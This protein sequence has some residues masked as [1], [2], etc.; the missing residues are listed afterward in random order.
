MVSE[1]QSRRRTRSPKA[2]GI[3]LQD[4]LR[5]VDKVYGAYGHG[6]FSRAE[7]ASAM[8]M[9]AESG[10]FLN[11]VGAVRDYG[12]V[13]GRGDDMRVTD[14][15]RSIYAAS[16]AG[17]EDVGSHALSAIRS[18][19]VLAGLLQEFPN[20]IPDVGAIAMRLENKERFNRGR[21]RV[22]AEAFRSSLVEFGLIDGP[23]N[24]VRGRSKEDPDG[25]SLSTIEPRGAAP[26]RSGEVTGAGSFRIEIPLGSG[27]R[28]VLSLPDDLAESDVVR[29]GA[30]LR[31][32]V[33]PA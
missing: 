16:Q 19:G 20:R 11:K 24:L 1:S 27:R 2:P 31:G 28:A 25:R 4:A 17:T 26:D 23:G 18:S 13:D 29:I 5:E 21:A 14:L 32:F 6:A 15:Y 30:V 12:L 33:D 8:G 3:S 22:V 9:S 10:A 7:L